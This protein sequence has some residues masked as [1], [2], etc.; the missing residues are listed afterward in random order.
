MYTAAPNY[1]YMISN[2]GRNWV[3]IIDR[4]AGEIIRLVA[5][6]CL[7]GGQISI[8]I[9]S[10]SVMKQSLGAYSRLYIA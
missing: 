9:T 8:G 6:V 7:T 2:A 4:E 5:S 10:S 3:F 1:Y